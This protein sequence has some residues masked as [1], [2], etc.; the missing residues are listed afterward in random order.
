MYCVALWGGQVCIVWH[1]GV[2]FYVSCGIVGRASIY[3]MWH[4][5]EGRYVLCGIVGRAGMYCVA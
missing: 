3:I 1:S 5:G 4:S 2:E